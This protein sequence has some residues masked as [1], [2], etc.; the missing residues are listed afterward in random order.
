[1]ERDSLKDFNKFVKAS[2][3]ISAE[4][5]LACQKYASHN[6]ST[7]LKYLHKY[8]TSSKVENYWV[9]IVLL[10]I[11]VLV[12]NSIL[13]YILDICQKMLYL[14]LY[15]FTIFILRIIR[16]KFKKTFTFVSSV[17]VCIL[18][19]IKHFALWQSDIYNFI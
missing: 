9:K 5:S 7:I 16:K 15:F 8:F 1:M 12:F 19:R 14:L 13:S 17:K 2:P 4:V 11:F 10:L 6:S 18:K 3:L